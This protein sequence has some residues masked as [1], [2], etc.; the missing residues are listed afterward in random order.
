MAAAYHKLGKHT[1][2]LEHTDPILDAFTNMHEERRSQIRGEVFA[3]MMYQRAI[4]HLECNEAQRMEEINWALIFDGERVE[5][6]DENRRLKDVL[7]TGD[8]DRIRDLLRSL[9]R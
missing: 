3:Q 9:I 7:K 2:V 1:D 5:A 6:M 8:M 4:A